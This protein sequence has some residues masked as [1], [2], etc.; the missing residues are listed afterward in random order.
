M[1]HSIIKI[2]ASSDNVKIT[3]VAAKIYITLRAKFHSGV[4]VVEL[5][6]GVVIKLVHT[7]REVSITKLDAPI[8]PITTGYP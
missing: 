5:M 2:I 6:V 4:E 1:D 7:I 3:M 8:S